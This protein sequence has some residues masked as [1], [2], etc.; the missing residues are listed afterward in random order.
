[1]LAERRAITLPDAGRESER[2]QAIA[3]NGPASLEEQLLQSQKMEAVG[4]LA[5][6]VAH[7]FNN[8]LTVINGCSELAMG[9]INLDESTRALLADIHKAGARASLITRQFLAFG[10]K[11]VLEPR[12][13]DL[14][15]LLTALTALLR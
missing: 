14:N 12:I 3:R 15:L 6:G 7:D 13:T 11:Q 10:R 2:G 1:M 9:D 4:R 5:A 8:L